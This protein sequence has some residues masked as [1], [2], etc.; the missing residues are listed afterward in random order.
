MKF[1]A[2]T[3]TLL[4][5][6]ITKDGWIDLPSQGFSMFPTI[7]SGDICRFV[8]CSG[9]QLKK[10]DVI[11]FWSESGQLIAHRFYY[12]TMREGKLQF[13]CKGDTNISFDQPIGFENIIGTLKYIQKRNRKVFPEQIQSYL[14]GSLIVRLP[15][16]S[17]I[18]RRYL[19]KRSA[20]L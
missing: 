3:V 17:G 1:D 13:F 15:M 4:Q 16:L 10:G 6:A 11:L 18:L 2:N 9:S 19:N 7:Q 20:Y 5:K 12:H 14:W 8:P